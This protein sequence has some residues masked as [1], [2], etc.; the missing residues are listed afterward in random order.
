MIFEQKTWFY[1]IRKF[2]HF[3]KNR[4]D[5]WV[6]VKIANQ[7]QASK[8]RQRLRRPRPRTPKQFFKFDV[9]LKQQSHHCDFDDFMLATIFE[10][11]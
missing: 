11:W 2:A 3:A 1:I 9:L 6:S 10:F 4:S 5:K 7:I 8:G